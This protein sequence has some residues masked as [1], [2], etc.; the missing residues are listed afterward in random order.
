MPDSSRCVEDHS[1]AVFHVGAMPLSGDH[2]VIRIM[3]ANPKP[4]NAVCYFQNPAE[5]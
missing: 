5:A 4:Q 1:G 2:P 3:M